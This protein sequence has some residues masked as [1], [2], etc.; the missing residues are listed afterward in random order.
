MSAVP[1][2]SLLWVALE[3]KV[4][5]VPALTDIGAQFSCLRS[6]VA[7]FLFLMGEPCVFG[8]CAVT[9]ALADGQKCQVTNVVRLRVKL[10]S[11]SWQHEFKVLN[12]GPFPAI[13]GVDFLS[14]TKLSVDTA[15]RT[16]GFGFA[17]NLLG[18]FS[19]DDWGTQCEGYL[20]SLCDKVPNSVRDAACSNGLRTPP[21]SVFS[22]GPLQHGSS[23]SV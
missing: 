1:R 13:L 9:C 5:K 19:G 10:L 4:G 15:S 7:E 11:F 17:P 18:H 22:R 8:S 3:F 12:G 16:F 6:D 20:Q 21:F 14:Q 23:R 2:N